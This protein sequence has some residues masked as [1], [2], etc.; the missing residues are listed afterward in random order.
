MSTKKRTGSKQ[1]LISRVWKRRTGAATKGLMAWLL[2]ILFVAQRPARLAKAGF[3]LPT[4]VMVTLVVTL[5]TTAILARSFDR[6]QTASNYRVSEEVLN[7]ALPALDRAKAKID[8]LFEDPNLPR[9]TPTEVAINDVLV[10]PKYTIGDETR[11]KLAYDFG[12]GTGSFTPDSN[13]QTFGAGGAANS[14]E[15]AE[16]L[17]TAWRFPADTDNSGKFDSFTLYSILFR[18]PNTDSMGDFTRQRTPLDARALPL[19]EGEISGACAAAVGNSS[20]LVGTNGWIM[21]SGQLKKSFFVYVA[22]V[23]IT[24]YVSLGLSASEY[25]NYPGGNQGFSSLEY[26]QDNGR[27]PLSNNAVVYEDDLGIN[28]GT[29]FRLNGRVVTNSNLFLTT[30]GNGARFYQVSSKESCFYDPENAKIV[31]GGNVV[32][33]NVD[34][35][36]NTNDFDVDLYNGE[37][38]NPTT[39]EELNSNNPSVTEPTSNVLYNTQAYER[40]I[41]KLVELAKTANGNQ[42]VSGTYPNL[43]V[44]S[45]D[46]SDVIDDVEALINGA[47]PIDDEDARIRALDSYFR[48]RTRRVPFAEVAA[49]AADPDLTTAALQGAGTDAMRPSQAWIYPFDPADGGTGTGFSELTLNINEGKLRPQATEFDYQLITDQGKES[50][51]GDRALIG[52]NLPALLY[53]SASGQWVGEEESQSIVGTEWD[54]PDGLTPRKRKTRV[55]VLDDLGDIDRDGFWETKAAEVPVNELDNTGGLRIVTDA[56]LYLPA[57]NGTSGSNVIWPDTMPVINGAETTATPS[58]TTTEN[59]WLDTFP[60]DKEGNDRP[61]LR[62]RATAV[63]HYRHDDDNDPSTPASPIACVDTYYDPTDATTAARAANGTVYGPPNATVSSVRTYLDYQAS[64]RYPNGRQVNELLADAL[65][66]VDASGSLTLAEQS[67]IDAAICSLQIYGQVSGD[68]STWGNIGSATTTPITNYTLPNGAIKEVSFLDSRQIK[69]IDAAT[70]DD[71]NTLYDDTDFEVAADS[72]TNLYTAIRTVGGLYRLP[73]EQRQPQEVRVTRIDIDALRQETADTSDEYMLPN[74]GI[75][76]ASRNDALPDATDPDGGRLSAN[77]YALD[78]TRR[79]NGVMLINGQRLARTDTDGDS[80]DFREVEKG[81]T[82]V[83]NLPVYVKGEFNPH[84]DAGG[85]AQEEFT[86][87]LAND[88]NN[89]YSREADDANDNF[90]CRKNDPRLPS[91]ACQDPDEWR[92]G[93]ILA[94]AVTL[95]SSGFAEGNRADG[96]FDLRNN[97]TDNLSDPDGD[98]NDEISQAS[99]VIE[100]RLRN[101]FWNNNYVTSRDFTDAKYSVG[102]GYTAADDSSYFNNYVTPIQRRL[103]YPEYIMEICRK[104]PVSECGPDDWVVGFDGDGDGALTSAELSVKVSQLG[105]AAGSST[106]ATSLLD[107][108]G[109]GTTARAA[110]VTA[111]RRYPRRVAFARNRFNQL[112]LTEIGANAT[113]QPM[114]V[115]CPLDSTG[116]APENNGCKYDVGASGVWTEGDHYATPAANALWF[117]G[118]VD[119]DGEPADPTR[120]VYRADRALYYEDPIAD[121]GK[122]ILPDTQCFTETDIVDCGASQVDGTVNL[123]LPLTDKAS[124][125]ILCTDSSGMNG[126]FAK[127]QYT[128]DDSDIDGS[129]CDPA[130]RGAID[131]AIGQGA[132]S[133]IQDFAE[134]VTAGNGWTDNGLPGANAQVTGGTLLA[135]GAVTVYDIPGRSFQAGITITLDGTGQ[136]DP[137]FVLRGDNNLTFN[138]VNDDGCTANCGV[139]LELKGV[140]P[141]DVFWYVNGLRMNAADA[142]RPHR[143]AGNFL[144]NT[145]APQLGSNTHIDGG[146]FLGYPQFPNFPP[147]L[148]I[149]AVTAD[150]QPLL[151]PVLQT[152]YPNATPLANNDPLQGIESQTLVESTNWLQQPSTGTTIYN[153]V[154]GAGD[155]P[156]R[157]PFS[158]TGFSGSQHQGDFNGGLPNLPRFLENWSKTNSVATAKI[159]GSLIQLQRSEFATS[160][161]FQLGEQ[162]TSGAYSVGGPFDY[163]QMYSTGSAGRTPFFTA[164]TRDWG[165]DVGLLSQIPDL[166]AQQF[167]AEPASEPNQYFREMS[168]GDD[169]IQTLLCA[170]TLDDNGDE[171][172]DAI[173]SD[174][175]PTAFCQQKSS[176]LP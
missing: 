153:M 176:D 135:E 154:M 63:Y 169:W 111:D 160:P 125:Y 8:A 97:Q 84:E 131:A 88:Y 51:T 2:R 15:N 17:T 24:D 101:G 175:R 3:V 146:R 140:D 73:I 9:G 83:S 141:N 107:R 170:K 144:G 157:P 92:T 82:L 87:A 98:S 147:G 103:N 86:E 4:V 93:N 104:L 89:F 149:T 50:F 5:L 142:A 174:Q 150:G 109:A 118:T 123:N 159:R 62:M 18:S 112:T 11:L 133:G 78:P 105:Q 69:A 66:A 44:S 65:T 72:L 168:R 34:G 14:F 45:S 55:R 43:S 138:G 108:L 100:A 61:F 143:L 76:Y 117:R 70:A 74:S 80:N 122:I 130:P 75:I 21:A 26:Q 41:D 152:Q 132:A 64:L 60:A 68:T 12:N 47:N 79:A 33:G 20:S 85:A 49:N 134:N 156:N 106:A 139:Q 19:D 128:I 38:N 16:S 23:P 58:L 32:Y 136:T 13:I 96:D 155:V 119:R 166:L 59:G 36:T 173:N 35:V 158:A 31:V 10:R 6:A 113:A 56:G 172:G 127:L 29:T 126:G 151:T 164:P 171:D 37:G 162:R 30:F 81:L 46:P 137:V 110:L 39:G 116:N 40:R 99:E 161:Y 120:I 54:K 145:A 90:A 77:D 67:A 115:G 148:T 1:N 95:L 163:P 48:Q 165:F 25:E 57:G 22:T 7:A 124:D 94:D 52:N 42:S 129:Q 53:D 91:T 102:T 114:G 27:I 167:L 28:P 71:A 121:G